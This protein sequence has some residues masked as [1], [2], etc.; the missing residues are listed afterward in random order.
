MTFGLF[1]PHTVALVEDEVHEFPKANAFSPV[2]PFSD[3]H[4]CRTRAMDV[5]G[6]AAS[7]AAPERG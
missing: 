2:M 4:L 3:L 6:A 1:M 7:S 5:I